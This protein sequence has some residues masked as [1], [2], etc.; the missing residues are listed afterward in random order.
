MKAVKT[1]LKSPSSE[2]KPNIFETAQLQF[3][4]AAQKLKLSEEKIDRLKIP[5]RVVQVR[6]PVHMDNGKIKMFDGY[7]VQHNNSRGPFKGGIRY[8]PNLDSEE[9]KALASWMTWKCAVVGIPFGGAKGGVCCDP[10]QL[11]ACE[12]EQVSRKFVVALGDVIGP[13]VD[14]PAPDMNTNPQI[15]AWMMDAYSQ[16]RG[17]AE[18]GAF[19]GKPLGLGGSAGRADATARGGLYVIERAIEQGHFS[20]IKTLEGTRIAVQGYGNVGGFAARLFHKAG[21]KIIAVSDANGGIFSKEGLN[22]PEVDAW[23]RKTGSVAKFS[24]AKSISQ[25]ELLTLDCDILIPAAMENQITKSIA[26]SV[27]AKVVVELANGPTTPAADEI[28]NKRKIPIYPDILANA[29]GV[30]VSYFEWVQN[31]NSDIWTEEEVHNKLR[32]RMRESYDY[33]YLMAQKE[34]VDIRTAAYMVSINR[35]VEAMDARGMYC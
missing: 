33:V 18:W 20:N 13:L 3:L 31:L 7:R 11:S 17:K 16:A 34:K 26:A 5:Q 9:V 35:V 15:M 14:V 6:F 1:T 10:K 21:A 27:K 12:L 19:T 25:D 32:S 24:G 29:G 8:A 30:T 4:R 28:L 22:I 2:D 23:M